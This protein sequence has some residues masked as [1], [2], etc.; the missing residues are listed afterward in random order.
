MSGRLQTFKIAGRRFVILPELEYRKLIGR[1]KGKTKPPRGLA[2]AF[3]A[4]T[5]GSRRGAPAIRRPDPETHPLGPGE[6]AVGRRMNGQYAVSIPRG[7]APASSQRACS[8]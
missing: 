1:P 5:G 6:E 7:N 8:P 4:G 2:A 3:H